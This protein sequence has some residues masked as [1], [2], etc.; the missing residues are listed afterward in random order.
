M[1]DEVNSIYLSIYLSIMN[2]IY[3]F[4]CPS[5]FFPHNSFS[6]FHASIGANFIF[7]QFKQYFHT[8]SCGCAF[9]CKIVI[10]FSDPYERGIPQ[11]LAEYRG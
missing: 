3:I 11:K 6:F 10:L 7:S 9:F 2:S 4:F 5:T 1:F 8:F